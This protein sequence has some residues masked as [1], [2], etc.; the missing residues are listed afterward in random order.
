M[1][2]NFSRLSKEG[3]SLP[4][5]ATGYIM[6]RQASLTEGQDQRLLTWCDGKYDKNTIT[7]AIR[8]LD[9][10]IKEK[11]GKSHFIPEFEEVPE[12]DTGDLLDDEDENFVYIEE[13]DLNEV[14]EEEDVNAALASYKEVREALRNQRN[15]RGYFP[16][17]KG[18]HHFGKGF[19]GKGKHRVHVE[20]LKLRTRC[21][22]CGAIG[23]VSRECANL[24]A[25]RGKGASSQAPTNSSSTSTKSGFFVVS[26]PSED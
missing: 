4:D 3:V 20:Q 12:Y 22:R 23:H 7:K 5:G 24:P 19:K 11:G 13:G 8:K 2:K 16:K 1:E 17:G 9:K 10:V 15:G 14:M 25:D 21:W 6:Y 26:G 18:G